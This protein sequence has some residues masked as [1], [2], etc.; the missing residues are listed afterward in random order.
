MLHSIFL[1]DQFDIKHCTFEEKKNKIH[2]STLILK[3][4]AQRYTY[5]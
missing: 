1:I 5:F 3:K 4:K 2:S